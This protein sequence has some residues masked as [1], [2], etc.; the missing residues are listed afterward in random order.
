M[1][2]ITVAAVLLSLVAS[3]ALAQKKDCEELK[4]E[5]AKKIEANGVKDYTLDVVPAKDGT[6]AKTDAKADTRDAK[7]DKADAKEGKVVGT[8]DGG[9]KKI[10][11]VRK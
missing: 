9:A 7:G 11:Y 5:I 1:K 2:R 10:T 8:C 6:E 3:P 4:G